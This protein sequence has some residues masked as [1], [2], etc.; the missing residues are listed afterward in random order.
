M[1]YTQ[2]NSIYCVQVVDNTIYCE[3]DTI[4]SVYK[5]S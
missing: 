5:V 2:K 4:Y 1:F 3:V